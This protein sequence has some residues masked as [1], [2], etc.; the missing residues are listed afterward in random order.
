MGRQHRIYII[1]C[2]P[3][4]KA[5]IGSASLIIQRFSRHRQDLR[6]RRHGNSHLQNAWNKYGEEAF[7][8]IELECVLRKEHLV[9]REQAWIDELNPQ[10]NIA[11]IAGSAL[12][13]K[14]SVHSRS[15]RSE[16]FKKYWSTHK[17]IISPETRAKISMAQMGKVRVFT[18]KHLA[19]LSRSATGRK[20]SAETK[21]KIGDANRGQKRQFTESHKAGIKAGW[22]KRKEKYG[23]V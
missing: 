9:A 15:K 19:A 20:L 4:G 11:R 13:V 18:D 5:Y 22:I 17:K 21:A 1:K 3:S 2:R 7:E 12:G 14:H 10:F 8:F 6:N 23:I 16:F